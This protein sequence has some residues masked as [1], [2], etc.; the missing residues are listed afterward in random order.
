MF[1]KKTKKTEIMGAGIDNDLPYCDYDNSQTDS[2]KSGAEHLLTTMPIPI[3]QTPVMMI[4]KKPSD[5][6]FT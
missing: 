6:I 2:R 5:M 4:S 1:L 3:R